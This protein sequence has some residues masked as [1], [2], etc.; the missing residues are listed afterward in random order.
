MNSREDIE[1]LV[2]ALKEGLWKHLKIYQKRVA[3][4]FI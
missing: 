2:C 1:L 3:I 4:N